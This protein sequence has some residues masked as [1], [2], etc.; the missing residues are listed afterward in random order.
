MKEQTTKWWLGTFPSWIVVG[1]LGVIVYF[2]KRTLEGF[3]NRLT[4]IETVAPRVM[5]LETKVEAVANNLVE[6]KR[7]IRD[8]KISVRN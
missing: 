6:I 7:D 5:V 8:I 1:L 2:S 4:A 3:E